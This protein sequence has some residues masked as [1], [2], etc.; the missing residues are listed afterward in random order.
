MESFEEFEWRRGVYKPPEWWDSG[1]HKHKAR[2]LSIVQMVLLKKK[3]L[4][5]C[6]L[7]CGNK[8]LDKK[9]LYEGR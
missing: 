2:T 7:L 9:Y 3:V 5:Y 1:D 6:N 8:V 4:Y